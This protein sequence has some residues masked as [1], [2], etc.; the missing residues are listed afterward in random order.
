MPCRGGV[1]EDNLIVFRADSWSEGGVNIGPG[2]A[3]E[4]FRFARNAWYCEDRPD[5]SRPRL[6]V[7]ETEGIYGQDPKTLRLRFGAERAE[8]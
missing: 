4:S 1:V 6:P 3:P 8:R 2:T 7:S 5:R